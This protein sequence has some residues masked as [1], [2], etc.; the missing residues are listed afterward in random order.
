MR[1]IISITETRGGGRDQTVEP[2]S[3]MRLMPRI[4]QSGQ[5]DH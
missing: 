3:A 4:Y 2:L 5:L 1:A